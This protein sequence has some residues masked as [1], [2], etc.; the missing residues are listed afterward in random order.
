M[1]LNELKYRD[2]L[3]RNLFERGREKINAD[4]GVKESSLSELLIFGLGLFKFYS[5]LSSSRALG[6]SQKIEIELE[7]IISW[8][9]LS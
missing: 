4:K 8:V 9:E 1:H 3:M 7:F 2:M 6:K 5:S